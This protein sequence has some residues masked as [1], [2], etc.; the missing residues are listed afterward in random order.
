MDAE[1]ALDTLYRFS[2]IGYEKRSGYGGTS[3]AFFYT[4]PDAAWDLFASRFKV[5]IGLKEFARLRE[6]RKTEVGHEYEYFEDSD[7]FRDDDVKY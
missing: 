1:H 5:H 4:D 7:L 3:W 2:V 6:E